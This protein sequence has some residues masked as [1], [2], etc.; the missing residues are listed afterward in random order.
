MDPIESNVQPAPTSPPSVPGIPT[1]INELPQEQMRTNLQDLMSKIDNKYQDFN[2][3]K[4]SSD[5]ATK[6]GEG[7]VLRQIFDLLQAK[8]IDPSNVEQ[9]KAFLDKIK[10]Q[11]PGLYQQIEEALKGLIGENTQVPPENQEISQ[12][13]N[14]AP[15]GIDPSEN[16]NINNENIQATQKNI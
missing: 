3:Q 4:F 12:D 14:E 11:D 5:N 9:V 2:A 7:E 15:K 1:G 16:M 6:E 8:G 13:F 10:E